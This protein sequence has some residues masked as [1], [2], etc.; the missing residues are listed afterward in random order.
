M[1]SRYQG[2]STLTETSSLWAQCNEKHRVERCHVPWCILLKQKFTHNKTF[3][4]L[5]LFAEIKHDNHMH[6]LLQVNHTT[7]PQPTSKEP[8]KYNNNKSLSY[9]STTTHHVPSYKILQSSKQTTITSHTEAD[10]AVRTALPN[11]L[12]LLPNMTEQQAKI[13]TYDN[14]TCHT[15]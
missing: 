2:Q 8:Q 14:S 9:I 11:Q 4:P 12:E 7:A 13:G 15:N 10:N 6:S 5:I 3:S 1:W